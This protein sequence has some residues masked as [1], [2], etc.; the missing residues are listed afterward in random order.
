MPSSRLPEHELRNTS[1]SDYHSMNF[2]KTIDKTSMADTIVLFM[3]LHIS[4]QLQSFEAQ[5]GGSFSHAPAVSG[6]GGSA[7]VNT[8]FNPTA[9]PTFCLIDNNMQ[10]QNLDI[11]PIQSV[12]DI[13]G[14]CSAAGFSP[15]PT[16]CPGTAATTELT[17]TDAQI[18]PN[19]SNGN[20]SIRFKGKVNKQ[21]KDQC[22]PLFQG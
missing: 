2:L 19:P 21:H 17:L 1:M 7:A 18:F 12:A 8:D 11:W 10:I 15:T 3:Y 13:E 4:L 6:D 5:H 14:A 20:V 22:S 9:Y 16:A